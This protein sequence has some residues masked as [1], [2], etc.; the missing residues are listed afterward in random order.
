[1]SNST[2]S[3]TSL[4]S[5]QST[6]LVKIGNILKITEKLLTQNKL[7]PFLKKNGKY[8]YVDS[9]TMKPVLLN[10]EYDDAHLFKDGLAQIKLKDKC[11]FIDNFGTIVIPPI[12]D[13]SYNFYEGHAFC[14]IRWL[15]GCY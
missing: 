9:V 5:I 8:I 12:Y 2:N 11:G 1:M 7:V 10:N 4:V 6:E 3:N 14:Y 13:F 15:Q